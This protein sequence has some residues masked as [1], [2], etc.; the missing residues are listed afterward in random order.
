MRIKGYLYVYQKGYQLAEEMAE[1]L[2]ADLKRRPSG[3]YDSIDIAFKFEQK[4]IIF[5]GG[6]SIYR[7][8]LTCKRH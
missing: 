2:N 6:F 3:Y 7:W 5:A 1:S 4:N 8:K